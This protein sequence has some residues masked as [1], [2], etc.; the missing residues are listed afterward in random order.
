MFV[1]IEWSVLISD[2]WSSPTFTT[3]STVYSIGILFLRTRSRTPILCTYIFL[4]PPTKIYS[5]NDSYPVKTPRV[6][7]IPN[8]IAN[9][10]YI[11]YRFLTLNFSLL[12][13]RIRRLLHFTLSLSPWEP[14]VANFSP[15]E[16]LKSTTTNFILLL[17]RYV[18]GGSRIL[19]IRP[20]SVSRRKRRI[21]CVWDTSFRLLTPVGCRPPPPPVY[22]QGLTVSSSYSVR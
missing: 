7:I 12:Y 22:L 5:D 6:L 3:Y 18:V 15:V 4:L 8:L 11:L 9:T 13:P 21:N 14:S 10:Y 16:R 2:H 17:L 19:C 20:T 1:F